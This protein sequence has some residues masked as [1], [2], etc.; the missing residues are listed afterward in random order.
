VLL[1][2]AQGAP[3]LRSLSRDM[4]HRLLTPRQRLQ[5]SWLQPDRRRRFEAALSCGQRSGDDDG[6]DE[7]EAAGDDMGDAGDAGDYV[8]VASVQ[9]GK[10]AEGAPPPSAAAMMM[11]APGGGGGF[12]AAGFMR[13]EAA[14]MQVSE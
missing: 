7:T 2:A 14:A 3:A 8:M 11:A 5:R 4:R 1:A 10:Q 6:G 12:G 13:E 9:R